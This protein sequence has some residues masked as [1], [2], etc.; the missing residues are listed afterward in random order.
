MTDLKP[1]NLFLPGGD[2]GRLKLLDFGIARRMATSQVM[3]RTGR[4]IG[5][6]E[7]MAPEQARGERELTAAADIFS[8][9][10][11][12]FELLP[13]RRPRAGRPSLPAL[14]GGR[15]GRA[16]TAVPTAVVLS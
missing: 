11:V 16:P 10:C 1:S 13:R 9:G 15:S 4:V 6:P 14:G 5:T 12:L 7:Y 3:T 8:L 2:V